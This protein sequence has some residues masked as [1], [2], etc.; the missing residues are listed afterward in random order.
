MSL[1]FGQRL[2][3]YVTDS[4]SRG[5]ESVTSHMYHIRQRECFK[6]PSC[7]SSAPMISW[8]LILSRESQLSKA[9]VAVS[10]WACDLFCR[11]LPHYHVCTIDLFQVLPARIWS[12][13]SLFT[14]HTCKLA[15]LQC[16]PARIWICDHSYHGSAHYQLRKLESDTYFTYHSLAHYHKCKLDWIQV[17]PARIR[18][19]YLSHQSL[20]HNQL[21]KLDSD[22][23]PSKIRIF[24][25]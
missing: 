6:G 13:D 14:Y 11:G 17:V 24:I 15:S 7:W 1:T 23:E 9:H 10:I 3:S 5:F 16:T 25:L 22:R 18:S 4:S 19:R 8:P 20:A 2:F 12:Y 21:C